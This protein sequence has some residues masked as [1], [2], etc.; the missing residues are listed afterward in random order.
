MGI[1]EVVKTSNIL[2][3][4]NTKIDSYLSRKKINSTVIA[5]C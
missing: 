3:A 2:Y 1:G 4:Y 5:I